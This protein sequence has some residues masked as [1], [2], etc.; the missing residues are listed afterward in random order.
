LI[1][2]VSFSICLVSFFVRKIIPSSFTFSCFNLSVSA[3]ISSVPLKAEI[4]QE[5]R[6]PQRKRQEAVLEDGEGDELDGGGVE[7]AIKSQEGRNGIKKGCQGTGES[8]E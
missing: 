2:S 8:G 7:L 4:N 5:S 3:S 6:C 1:C